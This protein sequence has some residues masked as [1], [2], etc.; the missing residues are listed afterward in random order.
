MNM[1]NRDQW[2][3][4]TFVKDR[5]ETIKSIEF[6]EESTLTKSDKISKKIEYFWFFCINEALTD[7]YAYLLK[8]PKDLTEEL[9]VEMIYGYKEQISILLAQ[10]T[11]YFHDDEIVENS[12][13]LT[14]I[15]DVIFCYFKHWF[16]QNDDMSV[17]LTSG[18]DISSF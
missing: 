14:K 3:L 15:I 18:L 9:T 7:H 11:R 16:A 10:M 2:I 17:A 5:L 13:C 12:L 8:N 4:A 6:K 1:V